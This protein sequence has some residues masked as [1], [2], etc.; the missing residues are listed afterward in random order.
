[1]FCVCGEG[2]D[3]CRLELIQKN[4]KIVRVET[5]EKCEGFAIYLLDRNERSFLNL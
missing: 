2:D 3:N 4:T 5:Q 1:M